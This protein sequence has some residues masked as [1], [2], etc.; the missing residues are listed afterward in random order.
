MNITIL[1]LGT[2]GDVQPYVALGQTLQARG[3]HVTICTGATFQSFITSHHLTFHPSTLDF[4]ALIQTEEGKALF[5]GGKMNPT[6]LLSF[7]KQV[8]NP[9]YRQTMD[10]FYEASRHSDLIIYHPK[11]LGAT[12]IAEA[13][14]IHALCLPPVPMTYP[15][16]EFANFALTLKNLGPKLNALSYKATDYAEASYLKLINDFRKNTLHLTKRK[17]ASH[18]PAFTLYPLS[19]H[20]F[21]DVKSWERAPLVV[22]GFFY[23]RQNDTMLSSEILAFLDNGPAPIVMTFSSMPLKDPQRLISQLEAAL[24]QTNNRAILLTG[25]T[26]VSASSDQLLT[27][28]AAPHHLLFARAKGIIHHGG[29]GTLAEALLSGKPQAI[30]P[31]SVDQPFWAHRLLTLNLSVATLREKTLDCTQLVQVFEAFDQ[32]D[33]IRRALDFANLLHQEDGVTVAADYIE[34]LC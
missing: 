18:Q 27:V 20:L 26:D 30:I 22:S 16:P 23:L 33:R 24:E 6:K 8:I 21:E 28:S 15:T 3:H 2:R 12:D 10:D 29:V 4:M 17:A 19:R 1:T 7:I 13:L 11:A 25:A 14:D 34:T 9:G 31:F 32:P 5:N